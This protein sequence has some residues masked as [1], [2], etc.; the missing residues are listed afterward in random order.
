MLLRQALLYNEFIIYLNNLTLFYKTEILTEFAFPP[1]NKC[2]IL[3]LE[4]ITIEDMQ[5]KSMQI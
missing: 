1:S 5:F 3:S 4:L 2:S